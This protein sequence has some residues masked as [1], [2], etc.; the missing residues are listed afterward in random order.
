MYR[1]IFKTKVLYKKIDITPT[2]ENLVMSIP[3]KLP[4]DGQ[5]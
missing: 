3:S 4:K 1:K 2:C 5:R